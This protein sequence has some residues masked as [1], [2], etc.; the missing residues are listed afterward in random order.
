MNEMCQHLTY[1]E[2][3]DGK[4]F[5][6]ARAFCTVTESFVQPMRADICNARYDLDPATDCEFYV[7]SQAEPADDASPDADR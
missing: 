3:G 6:T 7:D 5:E 1:R 4:S 2:S